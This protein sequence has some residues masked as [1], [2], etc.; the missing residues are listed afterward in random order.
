VGIENA[1]SDI[2]SKEIIINRIRLMGI[3]TKRI[4]TISI[5]KRAW[6]KH[7]SS[8]VIRCLQLLK[9]CIH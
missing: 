6:K 1:G 7:S 4:F 8:L 2:Q 5:L 3:I 9:K